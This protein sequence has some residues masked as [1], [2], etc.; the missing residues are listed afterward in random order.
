MDLIF[1]TNDPHRA[2]IAHSC[3][4]NRLMVDLE[5]V[6]KAERQRHLD[7]WVSD[8]LERDIAPLRAGVPEGTLMVR[9]NPPHDKTPEEVARCVDSGADV[10]MLPMYTNTIEVN[11][12]LDNIAGRAQ[13]SLL[14]ET[15]QALARLQ[16]TLATS[17][18]R[19]VHL[20]LNDLHLSM[21]LDFMFEL[22]AGGL[23]EYCAKSIRAAGW[24]FGFGG[25]API[26]EGTVP[27]HLVAAEHVRLG[28]QQVF[29]T[30]AFGRCFEGGVGD[31][32][33]LFCSEVVALH[34]CF[35]EAVKMSRSSLDDAHEQLRHSVAVATRLI[36]GD[37]G[38]P[39]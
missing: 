23:T 38:A 12:F 18:P 26:G 8:H 13:A 35:E 16:D 6:G 32:V 34:A 20:G 27:T 33:D 10:L 3:G 39:T 28:S 2:A 36:Q 31:G 5:R 25:I 7:S 22:V 24:R 17:P 14:L 21:K 37:T 11:S 29:L 4:V 30:R 19:E 9:I 15:P 1:I